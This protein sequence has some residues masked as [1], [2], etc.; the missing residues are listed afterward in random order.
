MVTY[1]LPHD[2]DQP[3]FG[4][5]SYR[6]TNIKVDKTATVNYYV[7]DRASNLCKR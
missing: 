3:V 7:I 4:A 2:D 1:N 6:S 5:Y